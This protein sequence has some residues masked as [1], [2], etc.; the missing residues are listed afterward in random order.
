M[1][2]IH[3]EHNQKF[4]V[5]LGDLESHLEYVKMNDVL[6]LIHTYVPHQLRGKGIAAKLVNAALVYAKKNNLK[7]IP[8]CSYAASYIQKNKE[9]EKLIA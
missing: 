4:Y 7:I 5:I 6:D 8:S 3:D 2:I 1:E 9:Y